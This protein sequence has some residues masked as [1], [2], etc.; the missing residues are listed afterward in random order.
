MTATINMG[1]TPNSANSPDT[2]AQYSAD[3]AAANTAFGLANHDNTSTNSNGTTNHNVT[4]GIGTTYAEILEMVPN[5][6]NA[7]AGDT[8]TYTTQTLKDVHTVTFPKGGRDPS[9]IPVCEH[10][11]AHTQDDPPVDPTQFPTWGCPGTP[12]AAESHV[13]PAFVGTHT[14]DTTTAAGAQLV[15]SGAWTT[16]LS[17]A[18]PGNTVQFTFPNAGTFAYQCSIHDHMTG[19]V[20]AAAVVVAAPTL[21]KSGAPLAPAG[22]KNIVP[23]AA[24]GLLVT[25][26]A[27]AAIAVARRRRIA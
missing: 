12:P 17:A 21:P 27:T 7:K 20:L 22:G 5:S 11:G 19:Q 25:L 8:V 15:S 13:N 9:I 6:I 3:S 16:L 2:S 10:T 18:N 14:I 1:A 24:A 4:S 26:L 23:L